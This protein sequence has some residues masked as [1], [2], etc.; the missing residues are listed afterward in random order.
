MLNLKKGLALVLA[1]ATVFTFAP[2]S[3]LTAYAA[4]DAA[5]DGLTATNG[6]DSNPVDLSVKNGTYSNAIWLKEHDDKSNNPKS[7]VNAFKITIER[8][9]EDDGTYT[10][11]IGLL[12]DYANNNKAF[13]TALT[14]TSVNKPINNSDVSGSAATLDA[15]SAQNDGSFATDTYLVANNHSTPSTTDIGKLSDLG[16]AYVY[17][18]ALA[19]KGTYKVTVTALAEMSSNAKAL[20]STTFE[21]TI[22]A[23]DETFT[24]AETSKTVTEDTDF[25]EPY[26]INNHTADGIAK[27]E[28]KTDNKSVVALYDPDTT[29]ASGID[30]KKNSFVPTT[31]ATQ[32]N[33]I[34][35]WALEAGVADITF[36]AKKAD[37]SVVA[38]VTLEVTVN[39]KNGKLYVSY[40]GADGIYHTYTDDAAFQ[41]SQ[42]NVTRQRATSGTLEVSDG[43]LTQ[44]TEL[45]KNAK[46]ELLTKSGTVITNAGSP[47]KKADVLSS[48]NQ[49]SQLAYTFKK[50]GETP[51]NA[52]TL[53]ADGQSTVQ[54]NASSD[55]PGTSISYSLVAWDHDEDVATATA[56]A[57]PAIL[58]TAGAF[59]RTA[60]LKASDSTGAR[61]LTN[62]DYGQYSRHIFTEKAAKAYGA[63][64]KNGLVTLKKA[65]NNDD[66]L[67][68]IVTVKGDANAGRA[69]ST[70]A[71]KV[72]TSEQSPVSLDVRDSKNFAV[73]YS[74]TT[75]VNYDA[76]PDHYTLYLSMKDR[77]TDTLNVISNVSDN[78]I[79]VTSSDPSVVK[80]DFKNLT[81]LKEG[82]ATITV[83]TSSAPNVAG[84][85]T[86]KLRVVVNNK[87]SSV[88]AV[89]AK[90]VSVNKE[91]PTAKIEATSA[92]AGSTIIFDKDALFTPNAKDPSGYSQLGVT[93][94][95]YGDVQVTTTGNVTYQKNSG[96][97]YV[98]AYARG[99]NNNNPSTWTY[100]PVN[101]G[102]QVVDTALSVDQTPIILDVKGTKAINA[103]ASTGTAITYTSA[104]PTVASVDAAGTVTAN[105]AGVTTVTVATKTSDGKDGDSAT[106]AVIVRGNATITDDT[107]KKPS[108]VTGVKVTNLKGGK[109]KVTWTKQNQKNIKY[110]VKKTVGKKSAGKSVGSNKTTLSVKKGATVKVKVKAYIY[111]ATGKKLVGS[112]SKTVT[113][114]TDK[115]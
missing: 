97:V 103:S 38:T 84:I 20:D 44:G 63:I 62:S 28:Y 12:T 6:I 64:D 105:K 89:S 88:N 57:T 69:T 5:N 86:V 1:A 19:D 45:Y 113:K 81:A 33:K 22:P 77:K 66:K 82:R 99:D 87:V 111:D 58:N 51:V 9:K 24:L 100:V 52:Q 78:Y 109:V 53:Y 114:K 27:V 3:S 112:Y 15:I 23:G 73:G 47:V 42:A 14:N 17:F 13:G 54:I 2:L 72:G 41:N 48:T 43:T 108:K 60:W 80:A 107:V 50:L 36:E 10:K 4:N 59:Y 98:R 93:D 76:D 39:P 18:G 46:G 7:E 65:T 16:G 91:K 70:F 29:L 94:A 26:V 37:G 101:Y 49:E 102:E 96:T 79:T 71:I 35:L 104:D 106:I 31:A 40:T 75:G 32:T 74:S 92:V 110:Y 83:Q 34:K 68:V 25:E 115:K 8:K 61:T 56:T 90:S 85:A 67:Y 30:P 55:V 95:G 11:A 21:I